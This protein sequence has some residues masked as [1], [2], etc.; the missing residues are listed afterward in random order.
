MERLV[1]ALAWGA[2]W[3]VGSTLFAI[4]VARLIARTSKERTPCRPEAKVE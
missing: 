4:W 1:R 3:G 2:A